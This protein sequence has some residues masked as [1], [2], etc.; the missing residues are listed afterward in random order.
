V[1]ER[2]RAV[3][4]DFGGVLAEE[5]FRQA[6]QALAAR[7]HLDE[8]RMLQACHDAIYGSG[9]ITGRGSEADFWRALRTRISFRESDDEVRADVLARFRLRPRM[10]GLARDLRARNIRCALVSDQIDWLDRLD[11]REPFFHEFDRLYISY[12]LGKGKADASLF[13]DVVA[14]LGVH[15]REALLVD[16]NTGNIERAVS[17]GLN[18]WLFTD[19]DAC[20]AR[21]APLLLGQQGIS[22]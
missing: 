22:A 21:V 14:D 9:F 4:F 7:N 13:D 1:S 12:R 17:R 8:T 5:G 19:E 11:A 10:L 6:L 15:P 20:L 18:A 2:L 3:L 16:D